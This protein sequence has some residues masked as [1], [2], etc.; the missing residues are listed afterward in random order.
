MQKQT[1]LYKNIKI[2]TIQIQGIVMIYNFEFDT[3]VEHFKEVVAYTINVLLQLC[4]SLLNNHHTFKIVK[5]IFN[6]SSSMF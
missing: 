1:N 6:F 2:L 5:Y 4:P 3:N